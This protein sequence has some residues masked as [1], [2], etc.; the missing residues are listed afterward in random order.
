MEL[1]ASPIS[2]FLSLRGGYKPEF[3]LPS[4]IRAA[5]RLVDAPP[6]NGNIQKAAHPGTKVWY[7]KTARVL[8]TIQRN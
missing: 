1:L 2:E 4:L 8:P 7:L 3:L 6:F 5:A